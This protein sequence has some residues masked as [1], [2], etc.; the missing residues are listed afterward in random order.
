ML[1]AIGATLGW[2][3]H[4]PQARIDGPVPQLSAMYWDKEHA[5]QNSDLASVTERQGT[6]KIIVHL[7]TSSAEKF[8]TA[9]ST[10]EQLLETYADS[11][12]GAEIEVVANA[13]AGNEIYFTSQYDDDV[14]NPS[15]T[16]SNGTATVEPNIVNTCCSASTTARPAGGRSSNP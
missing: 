12:K 3:S 5:F 10:A 2:I 15:D 11:D 14:G 16:E 9:L 4:Q 13:S 7:N 1:L 6:K 8:E